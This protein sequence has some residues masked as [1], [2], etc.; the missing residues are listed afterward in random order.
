MSPAFPPPDPD[1]GAF[2]AVAAAVRLCYSCRVFR[3]PEA[4]S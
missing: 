2:R 1:P 3:G 4:T